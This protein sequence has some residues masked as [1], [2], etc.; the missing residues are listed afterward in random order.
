MK[1]DVLALEKYFRI[2]DFP[3]LEKPGIYHPTRCIASKKTPQRPRL[4]NYSSRQ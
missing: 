4:I 3:I 1:N 2:K